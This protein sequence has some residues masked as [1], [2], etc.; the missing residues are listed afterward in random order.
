MASIRKSWRSVR[1]GIGSYA[2]FMMDTLPQ[3]KHFPVSIHILRLWAVHFDNG[4]TLRTYISHLKFAHRVLN[5]PPIEGEEIIASI[6]RGARAGM[7]RHVKPR[8]VG[9]HLDSMIHTAIL[10]HDIDAA[11][12]YAVAYSFLFRCRSELFG[13]QIDGRDSDEAYHSHLVF[14][15]RVGETPPSASVHLSSR[16]NSQ[17]GA[18]ISR[19]CIC[20]RDPSRR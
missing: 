10:E 14:R 1:A 12:A 19:P 4:D 13:I 8:V 3:V 2:S 6:V 9:E 20:R 16:K 18:V 7:V 5:L 11:R 17:S 15:R